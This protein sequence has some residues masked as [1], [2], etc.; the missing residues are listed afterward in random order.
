M[1]RS[2]ARFAAPPGA[3]GGHGH[4]AQNPR[5]HTASRRDRSRLSRPA[6]DVDPRMIGRHGARFP[7]GCAWSS[8]TSTGSSTAATSRI[9]GRA[10]AD[11][12]APRR[13]G[14]RPI[15]DEQLDGRPRGLRRTPGGDGDRR[16]P[17]RSSPRRRRRSSTS[18]GMPRGA[19]VLAIGAD[20]MRAE[21]RPPAS[22]CRWPR[23]PVGRSRRAAGPAYDAVVVGLDPQRRLRAPRGRDERRS[24]GCAADR[25]ERRRALSDAGRFP[26]RRRRDRGGAGH[27]HRRRRP[28]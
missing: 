9:R 11:R 19:R 28:R 22:R 12:R 20:G 23:M 6:A 26:A 24:P 13:R 1:V 5:H 15:R 2:A 21:L 10:G 8:S 27:R 18:A 14:G 25:H 17:R 7:P 4:L 16:P 3:L